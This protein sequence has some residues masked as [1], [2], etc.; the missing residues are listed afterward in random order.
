MK[1]KLISICILLVPNLLFANAES[2]TW[3]GTYYNGVPIKKGVTKEY[4]SEHTPGTFIHV[5]K[6]ALKHPLVTNKRIILDHATF[7]SDKVDSIYLLHGQLRA[8]KKSNKVKWQDKID[9]FLYKHDEAGITK[10]VWYS[11]E[12][13]GLYKGIVIN[14]NH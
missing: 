4:C 14:Q 12:C 11:S 9:Y 1:F 2:I 8:M 5:V 3:K 7:N 10:G 6:D 13:K